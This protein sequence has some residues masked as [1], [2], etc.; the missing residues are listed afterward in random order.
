MGGITALRIHIAR[1]SQDPPVIAC[2]LDNMTGTGVHLNLQGVNFDQRVIS[3]GKVRG[4]K[5]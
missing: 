2:R 5:M 4:W 1:A 3:L